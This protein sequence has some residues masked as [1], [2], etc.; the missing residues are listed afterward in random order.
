VAAGELGKVVITVAEAQSGMT[1]ALVMEMKDW[2][3]SKKAPVGPPSSALLSA[4][5]PA[6]VSEDVIANLHELYVEKWMPRHGVRKARQIWKTQAGL[7]IFWHWLAPVLN[8]VD[9]V[10]GLRLF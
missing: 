4:L 7:L 9:K 10:R 8:L 3:L 1:R 6:T 2:A 5:L